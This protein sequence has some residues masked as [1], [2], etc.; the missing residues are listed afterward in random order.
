MHL[1]SS[2]RPEP[3][4][5]RVSGGGC[6][7]GDLE[8]STWPGCSPKQVTQRRDALC[9]SSEREE[10]AERFECCAFAVADV[11]HSAQFECRLAQP[12]R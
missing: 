1:P 10:N 6:C 4:V 5:D 3:E 9:V 7:W 11:L 12:D 8:K 2:D